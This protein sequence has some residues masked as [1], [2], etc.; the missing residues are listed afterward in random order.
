MLPAKQVTV[1]WGSRQ[2]TGASFQERFEATKDDTRTLATF[3]DGWGAAFE[4]SV[5]N[6]RTLILGTFAGE[7]NA[8]EPVPMHPLGDLLA[9]WAGLARPNLRSPAF[10][11]MRRLLAPEGEFLLLFNHG[12]ESVTRVQVTVPLARP[13]ARVRELT[14]NAGET[15]PVPSGPTLS[16]S[17]GML[18]E[19]VRVYRID[20]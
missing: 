9:D 1:T 12:S 10:I 8:Q 4:R 16:L 17:V 18:N 13:A 20:Y 19:S 11:E 2:F 6:G 7:R 3:D 14:L 15:T 5:G